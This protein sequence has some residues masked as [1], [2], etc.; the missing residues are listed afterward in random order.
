MTFFVMGSE[1]VT[2]GFKFVG[3]EG[4]IVESDE[5]I[6]AEFDNVINK[7]YGEI[8]ILLLTDRVSSRIEEK[9]MEWQLSGEYPL[10]VEIP[11][12]EGRM[13]GKTTLLES[14]RKAIGLSV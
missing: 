10:I 14:I 3:I 7:R 4:V 8:G 9:I 11:D 5:E 1:D 12:I 6:N 13:E 2:L